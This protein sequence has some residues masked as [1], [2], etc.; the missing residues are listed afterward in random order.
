M[1]SGILLEIMFSNPNAIAYG[2]VLSK[3]KG[4]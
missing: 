1:L 2:N 4:S 3:Y